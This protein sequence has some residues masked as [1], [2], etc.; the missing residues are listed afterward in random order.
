MRNRTPKNFFTRLMEEFMWSLMKDSM[1]LEALM[2]VISARI[3]WIQLLSAELAD[4]KAFPL[5]WVLLRKKSLRAQLTRSHIEMLKGSQSS[6]LSS[7]IRETSELHD[8][9]LRY[10]RLHS[11][12]ELPVVIGWLTIITLMLYFKP[13]L[14]ASCLLVDL[15]VA[16]IHHHIIS[17]F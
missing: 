7:S 9:V 13:V 17:S 5:V 15:L 16:R 12:N 4:L 10:N 6:S 1:F 11:E 14:L 2:F 3:V 8:V